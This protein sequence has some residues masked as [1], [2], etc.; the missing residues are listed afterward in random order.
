MTKKKTMQRLSQRETNIA[1]IKVDEN[2]AK[3]EALKHHVITISL[4]SK[5]K[6]EKGMVISRVSHFKRYKLH[7]SSR[8]H[9][10]DGIWLAELM[11]CGLRVLH[12]MES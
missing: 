5:C 7:Q 2:E 3:K 11:S 8:C 12:R 9:L 6:R 4:G 1:C 10:F